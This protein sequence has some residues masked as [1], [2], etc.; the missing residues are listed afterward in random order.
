MELKRIFREESKDEIDI[1]DSEPISRN[2]SV[3]EQIKHLYYL[4]LGP[5]MVTT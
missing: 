3:F 5:S 2:E 4:Y 1:E